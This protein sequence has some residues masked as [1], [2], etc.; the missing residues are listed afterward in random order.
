MK[1]PSTAGLIRSVVSLSINGHFQAACLKCI[2][3][4]SMPT[5]SDLG[6]CTWGQEISLHDSNEGGL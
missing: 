6:G 3:L 2:H 5:D 4:R 1:F